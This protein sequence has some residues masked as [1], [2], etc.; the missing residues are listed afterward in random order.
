MECGVSVGYYT[1][2]NL[3][4]SLDTITLMSTMIFAQYLNFYHN[5][6]PKTKICKNMTSLK[7][8]QCKLTWEL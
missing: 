4:I 5:K 6:T 2:S 3:E 8:K 7:G 1:T